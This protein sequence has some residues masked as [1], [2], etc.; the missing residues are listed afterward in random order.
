MKVT[1]EQLN[2]VQER[3]IELEGTAPTT[4]QALTPNSQVIEL[5]NLREE[6]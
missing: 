6:V 2:K 1:Q 5:Q 3:L 4:E